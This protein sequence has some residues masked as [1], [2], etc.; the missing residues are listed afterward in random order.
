MDSG[1][2]NAFKARFRFFCSNQ[3]E[4]N[5]RCSFSRKAKATKRLR[6][7]NLSHFLG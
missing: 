5:Y 3:R 4:I 2:I 6:I 1:I 7:F